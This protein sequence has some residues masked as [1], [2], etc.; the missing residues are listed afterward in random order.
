M[1]KAILLSGGIDSIAVGYLHREEIDLAI[2]IN[3][4]QKP[5]LTE[6]EVS[7]RFCEILNIKHEVITVNC[8]DLGLG[9]MASHSFM[10]LSEPTSEWWPFRNQLII[11]LAAMKIYQHNIKTLI[12]GSVKSDKKFKDGSKKFFRTLNTCLAMQEGGVVVETPAINMSSAELV[13][14]SNLPDTLLFWAHSCHTS[15][16]PCGNCNGCRKYFQVMRK[17]GIN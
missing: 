7:K 4:G 1:N 3:Y 16:N 11:T 13:K 2:T 9:Q 12:I 6:I 10:S 8:G 17:L 5:A 15:N 14:E